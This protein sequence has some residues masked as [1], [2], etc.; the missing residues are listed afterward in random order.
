MMLSMLYT[1]PLLGSLLL[2]LILLALGVFLFFKVKNKLAGILVIAVGL[3]FSLLPV[4]VYLFLM[5][6]V[7]V[8]G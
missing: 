6:N 1:L 8:Q 2:G 5:I 3:A 7:R 4:A